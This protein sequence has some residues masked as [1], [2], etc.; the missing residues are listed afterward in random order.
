[1]HPSSVESYLSRAL[2][3][4]PGVEIDYCRWPAEAGEV[5]LLSRTRLVGHIV[6]A[7]LVVLSILA[8]V[9]VFRAPVF[10]GELRQ[11][12]PLG[13]RAFRDDGTPNLLAQLL[14]SQ[15]S[16]PMGPQCGGAHQVRASASS[17]AE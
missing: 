14:P 3:A 9:L 11:A 17:S 2:G 1:M 12:L 5:Y 13:R 10:A 8:G 15:R 16:G 6:V 4:G 7:V